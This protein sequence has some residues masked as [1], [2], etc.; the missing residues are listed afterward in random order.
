MGYATP[1]FLPFSWSAIP[2][3]IHFHF[4]E[5]IFQLVSFL[6]ICTATYSKVHNPLHSTR[7]EVYTRSCAACGSIYTIFFLRSMSRHFLM[8]I[9]TCKDCTWSAW[10]HLIVRWQ[11]KM[12]DFSAVSKNALS[13]Q[14]NSFRKFKNNVHVALR[15]FV[16]LFGRLVARGRT[17]REQTDRHTHTQTKYRN[18]CCACTP[19]VYKQMHA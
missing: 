2:I 3:Y 10:T 9:K 7:V 12:A 13:L 5:M 15:L 17:L 16:S 14:H 4:R 1:C 8:R 11:T 19:R 18:P 6:L